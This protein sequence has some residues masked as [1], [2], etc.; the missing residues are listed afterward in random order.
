VFRFSCWM[1]VLIGLCRARKFPRKKNSVAN[2][3]GKFMTG[4]SVPRLRKVL[5]AIAETRKILNGSTL[6]VVRVHHNRKLM[7]H[8]QDQI[9]ENFSTLCTVTAD[10]SQ[11]AE[12]LSPSYDSD[13]VRYYITNFKVVLLFG[14][15]ELTAQISWIE[16]V[17]CLLLVQCNVLT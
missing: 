7:L 10:T 9:K 12:G 2:T 8:W 4:V 15:T 3:S 6:I 17:G 13:G 14:L 11:M 16:N 1:L 5:C